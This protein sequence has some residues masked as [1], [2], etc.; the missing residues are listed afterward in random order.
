MLFGSRHRSR[1][2]SGWMAKRLPSSR[3]MQSS[4][5]EVMRSLDMG[6]PGWRDLLGRLDPCPGA[7]PDALG[8]RIDLGGAVQT[9][10]DLGSRVDRWIAQQLRIDIRVRCHIVVAIMN[11]VRDLRN[12]LGLEYE[13]QEAMRSLGMRCALR[14][15]PGIE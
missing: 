13:V 1:S 7:R 2:H 14:D 10:L 11:L 4:V 6:S 8:G 3:S 5:G 12:H 15:E 9:R